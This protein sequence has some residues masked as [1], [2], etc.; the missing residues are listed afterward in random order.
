[1]TTLVIHAPTWRANKEGARS[2]EKTI[3][4]RIGDGYAITRNE[5][6]QI[7]PGCNVLVLDKGKG[8]CAEGKL[9]KLEEDGATESGIRRYNVHIAQLHPAPY[10]NVPLTRRGVAVL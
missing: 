8:R 6:A 1:M 10:R 9:V 2:F 3:E 5:F 7:T 4:S